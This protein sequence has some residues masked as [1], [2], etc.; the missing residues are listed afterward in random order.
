MSTGAGAQKQCFLKSIASDEPH[1]SLPNIEISASD[2]V[3]V[4]RSPVTELRD[5]AVSR[6]QLKIIA[7]FNQK[8]IVFEV[9]GANPSIMNNAEL[10]KNTEYQAKHGDVIEVIAGKYP[11]RVHFEGFDESATDENANEN[12]NQTNENADSTIANVNESKNG[13]TSHTDDT[14]ERSSKCSAA[15]TTGSGLFF[16]NS[17][18]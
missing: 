4:G 18:L 3:Y 15:E 2:F 10:D 1:G 5:E 7:D 16:G 11:Y 17:K 8:R 13:T 14:R 12:A 6:Q 9:V